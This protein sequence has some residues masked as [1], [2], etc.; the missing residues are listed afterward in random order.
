M[1]QLSKSEWEDL[2]KKG[3]LRLKKDERETSDIAHREML[4]NFIKNMSSI[5]DTLSTIE[6]S[7]IQEIG[8]TLKKV[9]G[10]KIEVEFTVERDSRGFMKK[11][12]AKER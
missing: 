8:N 5:E 1:K 3:T 6:D 10:K 2:M 9:A 7:L 4:R 12:I 11:I